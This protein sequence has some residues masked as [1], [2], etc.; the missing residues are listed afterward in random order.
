MYNIGKMKNMYNIINM[1]VLIYFIIFVI[2]IIGVDMVI[3]DGVFSLRIINV[4]C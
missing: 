1:F 2:V 3:F 4:V